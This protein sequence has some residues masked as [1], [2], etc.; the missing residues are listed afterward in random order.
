MKRL[1]KD[2]E[3]I[4]EDLRRLKNHQ[5]IRDDLVLLY[6]LLVWLF[7]YLWVF[8]T[9]KKEKVLD[10]VINVNHER[11]TPS[12]NE[13]VDT[14][15]RMWSDLGTVVTE[16]GQELQKKIQ[17]KQD[18]TIIH[19]LKCI[20]EFSQFPFRMGSIKID[21]EGVLWLLSG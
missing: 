5:F 15:N 19:T 16:K 9:S 3:K 2:F 1:W 20:D 11:L 6:L 17:C 18:S 8:I 4:K 12:N 10:K 21:M 14:S 13:L 7:N